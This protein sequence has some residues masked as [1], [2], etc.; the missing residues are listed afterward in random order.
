MQQA[1]FK[2]TKEEVCEG[3]G[4]E[5]DFE[6]SCTWDNS[7]FSEV[8]REDMYVCVASVQR[9]ARQA[10]ASAAFTA[11]GSRGALKHAAIYAN[12]RQIRRRNTI[13]KVY[14]LNTVIKTRYS[15][16]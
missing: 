16:K 3:E 9:I 8:K 5:K 10:S 12:C 7:A 1:D 4:E 15:G 2:K 13:K 11:A 6:N 14:N